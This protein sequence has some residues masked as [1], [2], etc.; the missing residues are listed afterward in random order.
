MSEGIKLTI[1][2]DGKI[3]EY[4]DTYDVVIHCES[5]Q[6]QNRVERLVLNAF[7][8][9]WI[10]CSERLPEDGDCRF[11]MCLLENHIEDA[12]MLCQFQQ[13]NGFGSYRDVYHPVSLGFVDT[14]FDTMEDIGYEKVMYWM[15][16][17]EPPFGG[18]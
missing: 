3:Q 15:K 16:L 17:P 7:K 12:P 6:E 18:E 13:E 11:Y 9:R 14:E 1:N 2:E 8:T 5:E 10:P 4:D